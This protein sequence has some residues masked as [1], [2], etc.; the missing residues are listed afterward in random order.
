M[1][2]AGAI[3]LSRAQ[4]DAVF[5]FHFVVDRSLA[6]V[7]TGRSLARMLPGMA[8]GTPLSQWL[9]LHRPALPLEPGS[10][11]SL[12][13][14]PVIFRIVSTSGWLRGELLAMED[15]SGWMFLGSPWLTH[16]G[17]LTRYGIDL[18]DFAAHDPVADVLQILQAQQ[19]AFDD[20]KA[21]MQK[22]SQQ[23]A[24]SRRL[25]AR[26]GAL[27]GNLQGGVLVEDQE[28]RILVVNQ[29]FCTLFG[30]AVEPSSLVGLDCSGSAEQSRH[31]FSDPDA[32]VDGIRQA[33]VERRTRT[34]EVIALKS[35]RILERDYV[36]IFSENDYQGH[37]W[38]YRDITGRIAAERALR[39]ETDR[40]S[41]TLGNIVDGVITTTP[42]GRVNLINQSAARMIA[43]SEDDAIG[44]PVRSVFHLRRSE[45]EEEADPV[46]CVQESGVPWETPGGVKGWRWLGTRDGRGIRVVASIAPIRGSL[47]N[48]GLIIVFRDV[49][50]EFEIDELKRD[51]VSAVS[52]E[53]RTPLTSMKG[54]LDTVLNDPEMPG[55][56]RTEFLGVVRNQLTRLAG[57]VE[58][59]LQFSKLESG[60]HPLHFTW[61]DLSA[62]AGE[63]VAELAMI[64]ASRVI[65]IDWAASP[66]PVEIRADREQIRSVLVNLLSNAIKFTPDHGDVRIGVARSG[67]MAEIVV[68]DTGPGIGPKDLPRLF[69]RFFRATS[70][71]PQAPGTGLGLSIVKEIV[72]RHGGTVSVVSAPGAGAVFTVRLPIQPPE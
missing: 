59:I 6:V 7:R 1:S 17:E 27:I 52:H 18:G 46:R 13:G 64:S 63:T 50:K 67:D 56:L 49:S 44:S 32:V 58:Q 53:L 38:H 37:L 68:S 26:L 9:G 39:I 8:P 60:Q 66:G 43:C 20:M 45:P 41:L 31:L 61:F 35:G 2:A 70:T 23:R 30:M 69:Q 21:V 65:A 34:G 15:G 54:F 62:L 19:M 33:L 28:R 48:A 72:T 3:G 29:A 22:L 24:E 47:D 57:M 5:P 51:F 16:A 14:Q 55:E 11:P 71:G 25:S 36:P 10:L 42:D 40:L 12:L 4:L